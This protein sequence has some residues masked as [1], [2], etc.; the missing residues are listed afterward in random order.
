MNFHL[1]HDNHDVS[2]LI[3]N[4]YFNFRMGVQRKHRFSEQFHEDATN[5]VSGITSDILGKK[6]LA[7]SMAGFS[8]RK[9]H[10]TLGATY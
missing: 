2:I 7:Q 6:F 8:S 10:S 9:N 1:L 4:F 3:K 5:L